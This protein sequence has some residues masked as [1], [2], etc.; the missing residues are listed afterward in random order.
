MEI[1][2]KN[3]ELFSEKS[4]DF[5]MIIKMCAIYLFISGLRCEKKP[6]VCLNLICRPL[7]RY[8]QVEKFD[9]ISRFVSS[10]FLNLIF[11]IEKFETVEKLLRNSI[12]KITTKRKFNL[13]GI[14]DVDKYSL[15]F[16]KYADKCA[17]LNSLIS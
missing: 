17:C 15:E 8:I 9:M 10:S 4:D 14:T 13:Y 5:V 12:S 11:A 16:L 7:P 2:I 3:V 6:I 1:I